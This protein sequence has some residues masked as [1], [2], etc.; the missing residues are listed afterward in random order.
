MSPEKSLNQ[1]SILELCTHMQRVHKSYWKFCSLG[2]IIVE[3]E[4]C[5]TFC[6][7]SLLLS[8][9]TTSPEVSDQKYRHL[10]CYLISLTWRARA[11]L[12]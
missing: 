9:D 12:T 8:N 2:K 5:Y 7:D 1:V 3:D 4:L 11:W 10:V 6:D